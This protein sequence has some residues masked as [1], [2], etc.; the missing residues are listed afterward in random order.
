MSLLFIFCTKL[1]LNCVSTIIMFQRWQVRLNVNWSNSFKCITSTAYLLKITWLIWS[2]LCKLIEGID[3]WCSLGRES[4]AALHEIIV[5][6]NALHTLLRKTVQKCGMHSGP[7]PLNLFFFFLPKL[8]IPLNITTLSKQY[9]FKMPH[10]NPSPAIS[11]NLSVSLPFGLLLCKTQTRNNLSDFIL[12][13][14]L[15]FWALY[16]ENE[17]P[18]KICA[19]HMYCL[20]PPL[21][22]IF[23]CSLNG[24]SYSAN[25]ENKMAVLFLSLPTQNPSLSTRTFFSLSY[26]YT[27]NRNLQACNSY[28]KLPASEPVLAFCPIS[29]AWKHQT[30]I[31]SRVK[32]F[33]IKGF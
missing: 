22:D 25:G 7:V 2:I 32:S 15:E 6:Q 33:Q 29:E 1:L 27:Q 4:Q 10:F 24:H 11:L 3:S 8:Q 16:W 18:V 13:L 19:L 9:T 26:T 14:L 17:T 5:E 30:S 12:L 28:S 31:S 20:Q 23:M 21:S